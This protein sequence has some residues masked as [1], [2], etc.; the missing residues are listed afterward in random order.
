MLL[1]PVPDWRLQAIEY[2]F[3]LTSSAW[4]GSFSWSAMVVLPRIASIAEPMLAAR[5][6]ASL[7]EWL[8]AFSTIAATVLLLSTFGMYLAALR[9]KPVLLLQ[10]I[11]VFLM[12]ASAVVP[13]V[14]VAPRL[15]SLARMAALGMEP[16]AA[17]AGKAVEAVVATL[18][19]LG[20][21]H[22]VA[23]ALLITTGSRKWFRYQPQ[24]PA[25]L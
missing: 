10:L 22:A 1:N 18:R 19:P 23:G 17:Q 3:L 20:F 12:V 16:Q 4:V 25:S 14:W 6:I 8:A 5:L 11:L 24:A 7:L 21:V 13:S 9:R 2:A 15:G